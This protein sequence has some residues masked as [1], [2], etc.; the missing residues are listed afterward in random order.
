VEIWET[1]SLQH[2]VQHRFENPP[3][4]LTWVDRR[5]GEWFACFA[6]CKKSSDPALTRV[7]KFDASWRQLATWAFPAEL[8]KRFA[9]NSS[10]GGAFGPA[11]HLFVTGHDASELYVLDVPENGGEL[12]WRDAI[13]ISAA[14]QALAWDQREPGFLYSI[15]R[16]TKEVI[17]SRVS[18][19]PEQEKEREQHTHDAKEKK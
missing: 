13:P 12:T 11:G 19:A 8:I 10:S 2:I 5:N 1:A 17:V 3:G 18:S 4:F 14:G 9:G 16:K 15:Q 7:V 6:H